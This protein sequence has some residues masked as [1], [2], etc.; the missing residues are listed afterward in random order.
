MLP[1]EPSYRYCT[2]KVGPCCGTN[3]SSHDK[4]LTFIVLKKIV[5]STIELAYEL[6]SLVRDSRRAVLSDVGSLKRGNSSANHPRTI[7]FDR[8]PTEKLYGNAISHKVLDPSK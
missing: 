3:G 7:C 6:D 2:K 5:S 1:R 8:S 4:K